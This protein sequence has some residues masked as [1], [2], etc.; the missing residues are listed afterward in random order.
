ML[1]DFIQ[2]ISQ[3]DG[4]DG[5]GGFMGTQAVFIAG[6]GDGGAQQIRMFVP[7]P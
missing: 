1:N 4:N 2:Q 6:F 3:E 5:R 7:R